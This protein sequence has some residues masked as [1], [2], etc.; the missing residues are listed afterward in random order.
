MKDKQVKKSLAS[1]LNEKF[2]FL[3]KGQKK[4]SVTKRVLDEL[5]KRQEKL[6]PGTFSDQKVTIR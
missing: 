1:E 5:R 6:D 2:E 3:S 4:Q